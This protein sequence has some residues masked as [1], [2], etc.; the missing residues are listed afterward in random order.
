V[1]LKLL[2]RAVFFGLLLAAGAPAAADEG[3][4]G[5]PGAFLKWGADARAAGLGGA[6]T[7]VPGDAASA[8]W[9]PAGLAAAGRPE[10][11]GTYTAI[12]AGGD[13]SQL[14]LALPLSL[15]GYPA[16]ERAGSLGPARWGAAALSLVRLAAAYDIEARQV[17]S[18]NPNYLFADVEGSYALAW[19][20]PLAEHWSAGVNLKGLY[21]ELDQTRANGLGGDAGVLWQ[22][23]DGLT[24]G[25]CAHDLYSR[26][27]WKTGHTDFFPTRFDLGAAYGRVFPG[28]H[29]WLACLETEKETTH[30]PW[31]FRAGLEYGW[32]ERLFLRG[33]CQGEFWSLGGGVR[34][35]DLGWGRASLN[36]DYA[37][38]QDA[39]D[40]WDHW[41]TLGLRF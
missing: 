5:A 8:F 28:G 35:P 9:N 21:H 6:Y 18:L 25:F 33:G 30:R 24:L 39:I 1:N 31:L 29:G 14:A 15:F 38:V 20:M 34:L 17:D 10:F 40:G 26:L 32:R 22:G 16:D 19:G 13:Y 7:A 4:A 12:P 2:R 23:L 3:T 37:A 11:R 27:D 41:M 36:L